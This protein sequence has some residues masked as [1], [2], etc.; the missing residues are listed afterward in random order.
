MIYKKNKKFFHSNSNFALQPGLG[1]A[2][3]FLSK[4]L[5]FVSERVILSRKIVTHSR[6]SFAPSLQMSEVSVS[7]FKKERRSEE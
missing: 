6:H 7:L 4:S 3:G 2:L 5:V 1:I